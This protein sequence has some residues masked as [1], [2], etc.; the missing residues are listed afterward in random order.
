MSFMQNT[1]QLPQPIQDVGNRIVREFGVLRSWQ[2]KYAYIIELGKK[3]P[4]LDLA[5]KTEENRIHGCQS[6]VWLVASQ[7]D[8][9]LW[10]RADADSAIVKGLVALMVRFYNG[11]TTTDIIATEPRFIQEIG[12]ERHFSAT[13]ANGLRAM[14]MRIRQLAAENGSAV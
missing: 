2:E 9:R 14:T 4:L 7:E 11:Q 5:D 1:R 12:M 3:L 13:R 6:N 8:G 10:L